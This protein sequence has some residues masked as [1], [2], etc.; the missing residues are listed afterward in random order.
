MVFGTTVF[1]LNYIEYDSDDGIIYEKIN[2]YKGI[3]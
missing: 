3:R 1:D 2:T